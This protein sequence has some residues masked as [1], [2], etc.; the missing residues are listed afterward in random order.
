MYEGSA[1][2]EELQP[3]NVKLITYRALVGV[4][5]RCFTTVFHRD[6]RSHTS[7]DGSSANE[8]SDE[9]NHSVKK[10]SKDREQKEPSRWTKE[11]SANDIPPRECEACTLSKR[12]I[13]AWAI[14]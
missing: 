10:K 8:G 12:V 14:C 3:W 11:R 9:R 7:K 1:M 2:A 4:Y 6:R 13:Y 5:V